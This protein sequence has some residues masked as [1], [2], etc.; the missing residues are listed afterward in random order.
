MANPAF[1]VVLQNGAEIQA[2]TV[3]N[4]SGTSLTT[5][6]QVGQ[7]LANDG[8]ILVTDMNGSQYLVTEYNVNFVTL[9]GTVTP[10]YENNTGPFVSL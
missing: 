10:V 8:T 3:Q 2:Q 5:L 9:G 1:I 7:A 4:T 6:L